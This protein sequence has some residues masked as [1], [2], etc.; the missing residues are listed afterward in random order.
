MAYPVAD[1]YLAGPDGVIAAGFHRIS[2]H[3]A[4]MGDSLTDDAYGLT[5]FYGINARCG[6]KMVLLANSGVQ[7]H[8]VGDMLARVDNDYTAASP[9]VAGLGTLGRIIFRAG[10]NN[11]RGNESIAS[12][13][14]TYTSMLNKLAGYAQRVIILAVPPLADAGNN[15]AVATYNS[16]LAS[17]AASNP[18]KFRFIDDCTTVRNS[19]GSQ[20]AECFNADGIHFIPLGVAR[21]SASGGAALAADF[22][23]YPSPLSKDAA[24]V[25]PVHP[26]WFPNPTNAGTSGGKGGSFTGPVAT[27]LWIDG[28]GSGMAGTCSIVAADAGDA[29]QTPWQRVMLSA[30]NAGSRLDI[31][32][33]LAGRAITSIDPARLDALIEVRVTDLYRSKIDSLAVMAQGNTGEYLVPS[34][35]IYF[36][37]TGLDSSVY[38]L[39]ARRPRAG[40][41]TPSSIGWHLYAGVRSA[42]SGSVGTID[43]RCATVR[44]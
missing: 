24:D 2:L 35:P 29:N 7:G 26:Q 30:G 22:V 36:D 31:S 15:A 43:V 28:Y 25:Y 16:W 27:G 40:S 42:F 12:L 44:G 32:A 1:A 20:I 34:T 39:R 6:G 18:S 41:S 19:D 5:T 14:A 38:V 13:A 8:T 11:A 33:T 17:F 10:T 9:G 37:D 23:T 3:T 21:A 4:L